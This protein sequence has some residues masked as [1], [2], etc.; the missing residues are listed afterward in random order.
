MR[1]KQ[2]T[3]GCEMKN[4]NYEVILFYRTEVIHNVKASNEEEA[5]EKARKRMLRSSKYDET[6]LE[7]LQ[8]NEDCPFQVDEED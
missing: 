1:P 2:K 8:E 4:I 3:K 7:N 5:V 6:L